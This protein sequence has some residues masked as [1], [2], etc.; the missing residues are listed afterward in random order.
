MAG[1]LALVL[2]AG[3]QAGA[4]LSLRSH[5]A[6]VG[7]AG[8]FMDNT[9]LSA[10]VSALFHKIE[11]DMNKTGQGAIVGAR[12]RKPVPQEATVP[13]TPRTCRNLFAYKDNRD[14]CMRLQKVLCGKDCAKLVEN[15]TDECAGVQEKICFVP[16][17]NLTSDAKVVV[18]AGGNATMTFC[19]AY[20]SYSSHMSLQ[21]DKFY[22]IPDP[23]PFVQN[24]KYLDCQQASIPVGEKVNIYIG[25]HSM[26]TYHV[27]SDNAIVMIGQMTLGESEVG[28]RSFTFEDE[29]YKRPILCSAY[30]STQLEVK[31]GGRSW[32]PFSDAKHPT[33]IGYMECEKLALDHADSVFHPETLD[34][35]ETDSHTGEAEISP[36]K[37]LYVIGAEDSKALIPKAYEFD[38]LHTLKAKKK[39]AK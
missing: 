36:V 30:P 3:L 5:A 35:Y 26:A 10:Q 8:G 29:G 38:G 23:E 37:S 7:A 11:A 33:S 19:N 24:L 21:H 31:V 14:V 18:E 28:I 6:E 17:Q 13:Y 1:F 27:G 20:V 4:A 16:K 22:A 12:L 9:T 32:H 25:N 34:F 15:A 39:A 2:T